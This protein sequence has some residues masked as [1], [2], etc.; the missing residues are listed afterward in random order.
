[1]KIHVSHPTLPWQ[2]P[3]NR[4]S[5]FFQLN[6]YFALP[7]SSLELF[8]INKWVWVY[9]C[10]YEVWHPEVTIALQPTHWAGW[11]PG[12]H[13]VEVCSSL[14]PGNSYRPMALSHPVYSNPPALLLLSKS[15]GFGSSLPQR[16]TPQSKKSV[17]WQP[18]QIMKWWLW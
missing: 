16:D 4:L 11:V 17:H 7:Y 9:F 8:G 5:T 1:M 15:K 3:S 13:P 10:N 6:K 14:S 2:Q 18:P 12:I